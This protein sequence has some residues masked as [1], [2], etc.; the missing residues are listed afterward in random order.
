MRHLAPLTLALWL[1]VGTAIAAPASSH[2]HDHEA[3]AAAPKVTDTD[4]GTAT[5]ALP[6]WQPLVAQYRVTLQAAGQPRRVETW[7]FWR[8]ARRIALIKGSEEEVWQR[9]PAGIR[10]Q[11]LYHADH[12]LVDYTPG[13]LR[14]LQVNARW[15]PLGTLIDEALLPTLRRRGTAA[16]PHYSGRVRGEQIDLQWDPAR[17]LPLQMTRR[18]A[19]G[20]VQFQRLAVQAEPGQAPPQW[21]VPTPDRS[22]Y[23]RVDAADFGDMEGDPFVRKVLAQDMRRGWRAGHS[24]DA[25]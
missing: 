8:D 11:R 12:K 1:G 15:L 3:H 13:E 6:D 2:R 5:A 18:S 22:D 17:R 4:T 9:E 20:S 19:Q 10:L 14:T 21:P 23:D 16:L 24:H 7:T 25:D